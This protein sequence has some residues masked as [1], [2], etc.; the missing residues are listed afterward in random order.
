MK[1]YRTMSFE[2]LKKFIN[3]ETLVAYN[4][5]SEVTTAS[6]P[7]FYFSSDICD[8]VKYGIENDVICEFE[9][10]DLLFEKGYGEIT[11]SLNYGKTVYTENVLEYH[12]SEYNNRKIKLTNCVSLELF[13][14]KTDFSSIQYFKEQKKHT[15]TPEFLKMYKYKSY[16]GDFLKYIDVLNFII[17]FNYADLYWDYL[18]EKDELY[19]RIEEE[20]DYLLYGERYEEE[21]DF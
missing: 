19:M 12:I 11:Y 1:L 10:N 18:M 7:K 17:Q 2:E 6:E 21:Q 16:Y 13:K 8:L 14:I 15:I 20:A 5:P 3:G 4:K 9:A